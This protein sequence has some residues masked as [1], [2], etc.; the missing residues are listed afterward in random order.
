MPEEDRPWVGRERNEFRGNDFSGCDLVDVAFRTG[1]D[2]SQQKLP[3]SPEYLYLSAAAAAIERA[4][5]AVNG[6]YDAELREEGLLLLKVEESELAR[7]QQQLLLRS[8]GYRDTFRHEVADGV[9]AALRGKRRGSV[10]SS[11]T[12]AAS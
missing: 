4:R 8:D 12:T 3:T 7:G 11:T 2:L 9:F 10:H 1:I 5:A 6:W